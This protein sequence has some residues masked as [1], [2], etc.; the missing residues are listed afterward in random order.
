LNFGLRAGL[1]TLPL[2]PDSASGDTHSQKTKKAR[3]SPGFFLTAMQLQITIAAVFT[4]PVNLRQPQ[5]LVAPQLGQ[6]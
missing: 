3:H 5:P 2:D 1:D 4:V 6:E